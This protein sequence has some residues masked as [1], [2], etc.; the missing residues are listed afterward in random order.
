[1]GGRPAQGRCAV[2][3]CRGWPAVCR[4]GAA[5]HPALYP[6]PI[7]PLSPICPGRARARHSRR[8]TSKRRHHLDLSH[9]ASSSGRFCVLCRTLPPRQNCLCPALVSGWRDIH[10]VSRCLKQ[11]SVVCLLSRGIVLGCG[12]QRAG[13]P[14]VC[15][16]G[17]ELNE[18]ARAVTQQGALCGR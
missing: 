1:M 5:L 4:P 8:R 7:R 10:G 17:R 12:R 14:P 15:R 11:R 2:R 9:H 3:A 16:C 18:P 13:P 6:P